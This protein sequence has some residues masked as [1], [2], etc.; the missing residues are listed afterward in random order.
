MIDSVGLSFGWCDP[1][2]RKRWPD[3]SSP[4]AGPCIRILY[5][6]AS[7]SIWGDRRDGVSSYSDPSWE[8]PCVQELFPCYNWF[9][10]FATTTK[11]WHYFFRWILYRAVNTKYNCFLSPKTPLVK[12]ILSSR[13]EAKR[14]LSPEPLP[15]KWQE[16]SLRLLVLSFGVKGNKLGWGAEWGSVSWDSC[17]FSTRTPGYWFFTRDMLGIQ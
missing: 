6:V 3:P 1:R 12:S 8:F 11:K 10:F 4:R 15:A 2:G 7:Y 17:L 5:R 14:L 16:R 13:Q 9:F